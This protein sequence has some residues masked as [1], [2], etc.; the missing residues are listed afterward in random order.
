[1]KMQAFSAIT[2]LGLGMWGAHSNALLGQANQSQAE[3]PFARTS[4]A[5]LNNFH[6]RLETS[7]GDIEV[8]LFPHFAPEHVRNFLRLSKLGFYDHTSWHRVV[9]GTIVQGGDLGTRIPPLRP[10]E[11][12][13]YVHPLQPEFSQLRHEQGTL[14]MARAQALDSAETS[15]FICVIPQPSLDD[16]YTIFGKVVSGMEVVKKIASVAIGKNEMPKKRVELLK[17]E[18]VEIKP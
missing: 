13:R 5:E 9:P 3:I 14:S 10:E 16:K 11:R 1:M 8:D 4:K 18:V 6:V 12:T 7:M 17:A 15:F 2:M